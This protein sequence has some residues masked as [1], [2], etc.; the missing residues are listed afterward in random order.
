MLAR[1]LPSGWSA[2]RGIATS[3]SAMKW[4]IKEAEEGDTTVVEME[5][6]EEP[7]R[8]K[9]AFC[10]L[11]TCNLPIKVKYSDVLILEQFMRP[12]GT[13]LPR[14]LTGL[15]RNKQLQIERCVM[16][17][18]WSGLFPDKTIADFDRSGYKQFNRYWKNDMSMY[19]I[20]EKIEQ[21]SWYY[22]KRYD[23]K[24]RPWNKLMK[25]PLN[26]DPLHTHLYKKHKR[27][28]KNITDK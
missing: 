1:C 2:I 16:Q 9:N 28:P 17:A 8:P 20:S 24:N 22:V 6:I 3:S 10:A 18:H 14:Q 12:D 21:G 27:K 25:N 11:C 4:K 13:V 26:W 7:A 19:R 23:T 5:K 15:C